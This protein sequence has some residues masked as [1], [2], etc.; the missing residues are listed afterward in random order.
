MTHTLPAKLWL[1]S[2]SLSLFGIAPARSQT[3]PGS[4]P[5]PEVVELAAAL[6]RAPSE[7]EQERLLWGRRG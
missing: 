5:S 6:A 2:L 1:L 3:V 7:Q 4:A